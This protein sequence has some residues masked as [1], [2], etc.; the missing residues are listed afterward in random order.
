M[1]NEC[2]LEN[3]TFQGESYFGANSEVSIIDNVYV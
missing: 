1:K 3:A 2:F